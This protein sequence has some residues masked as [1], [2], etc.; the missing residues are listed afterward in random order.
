MISPSFP[1]RTWD[2]GDENTVLPQRS[3]MLGKIPNRAFQIVFTSS[4]PLGKAL[5][6]GQIGYHNLQPQA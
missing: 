3:L 4:E 6:S 2:A 1:T 5:P